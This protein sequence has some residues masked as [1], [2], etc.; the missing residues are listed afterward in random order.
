MEYIEGIKRATD[1]SM[2]RVPRRYSR[3]SRNSE[4]SALGFLG[5]EELFPRYW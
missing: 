3:F 4:A 2:H 5:N 1:I